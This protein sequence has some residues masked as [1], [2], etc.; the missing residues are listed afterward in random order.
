MKR[1]ILLIFFAAIFAAFITPSAYASDT[2]GVKLP[3]NKYLSLR[4]LHGPVYDHRGLSG[5]LD[6]RTTNGIAAEYLVETDGS[7]EWENLFAQPRLGAAF[8]YENFHYNVLGQAFSGAVIAEFPLAKKRFFGIDLR[9]LAGT[10]YVTKHFDSESNPENLLVGSRFSAFFCFGPQFTFFRNRPQRLLAGFNFVH[11]SNGAFKLPN[12]GLNLMQW[13]IG[14]QGRIGGEKPKFEGEPRQTIVWQK[15]QKYIVG[16]V[17]FREADQ[18]ESPKYT[19]LSTT[20]GVYR[21]AGPRTRVGAGLDFI[22]DPSQLKKLGN[23]GVEESDASPCLLG[24][25]LAYG[26]CFGRTAA[27]LQLGYFLVNE[28]YSGAAIYDR[29]VINYNITPHLMAN[30]GLRTYFMRAEYIEWGVGYIF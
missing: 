9:F 11:W 15:W 3:R 18:P 23:F 12:L 6:Y 27:T 20:A 13:H 30:L 1:Y 28:I 2:S 25:H 7:R 4:Y 10:A 22:R 16:A 29:V 24:A 26:F 21:M 5:V 17:G 14:V 19:I 8:Y